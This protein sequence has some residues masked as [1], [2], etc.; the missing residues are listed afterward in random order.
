MEKRTRQE[1]SKKLQ[2]TG[3]E[4]AKRKKDHIIFFICILLAAL[5]WVLIKLSGDYA[6]N[7]T[8]RLRYN[9]APK[10]KTV[11][12]LQDSSLNIGFKANGYNILNLLLTGK[13][14]ILD[15]NLSQCQVHHLRDDIYRI[16]SNNIK[17]NVATELGI[18]ENSI[19]FSKSDLIFRMETVEKKS[20][21]ILP[22]LDLTF[23]SQHALYAVT[24]IPKKVYIYGPRNLIDS[25]LKINTTTIS[26]KDLSSNLDVKARLVNPFP[27]QI[28]IS[29]KTVVIKLEVEKF[30]ESSLKVPIDVTN[31]RKPIRTFPSY[32]TL[33]FNVFLKDYN[34]VHVNQ[35]KVVPDT[36]NINLRKVKKL[37][38]KLIAKPH[39]ISNVRIDPVEVE[40]LILN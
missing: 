6:V 24:T 8:L 37:N 26:L 19:T 15:I 27:H 23:K 2:N 40:F 36:K 7:Y 22:K 28:R 21:T 30:T 38:L 17:E 29:P 16:S 12:T 10:D 35:F 34:K 32:T 11:T 18:S 31:T 3:I 4:E 5:F 13:L 9:N 25:I 20:I 1:L 39:E 33:Y 14:K